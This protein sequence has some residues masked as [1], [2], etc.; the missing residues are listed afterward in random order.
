MTASYPTALTAT[1]RFIQAGVSKVYWVPSIASTT[2]AATRAELNTGSDLTAEIM[3]VTGF[4]T[5][6][7]IVEV[8]DMGN[9]FVAS[10]PGHIKTPQN[11]IEFY[12][13]KTGSDASSFF[14]VDQSG[15]L[16][17]L[18]GGDTGAS[19]TSLV[20]DVFPVRVASV[21]KVRDAGDNPLKVHVDFSIPSQPKANVAVPGNP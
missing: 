20:M 7:S 1:T 17:F 10:V 6:A 12:A 18:D 16:A 5:Q 2:L 13:S 11:S 8:P 19:T 14:T 3:S 15:Y 9:R 21:S 4:S